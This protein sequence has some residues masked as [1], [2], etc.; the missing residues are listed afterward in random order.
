M[1]ALTASENRITIEKIKKIFGEHDSL[2]VLILLNIPLFITI[3]IYFFIV[4]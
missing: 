3:L 2:F 4:K 1:K